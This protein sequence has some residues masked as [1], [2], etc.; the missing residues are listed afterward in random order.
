MRCRKVINVW[1]L[2]RS[3]FKNVDKN[4]RHFKNMLL[5][6]PTTTFTVNYVLNVI[7]AYY[8]NCKFF[9]ISI[10][11]LC[12]QHQTGQTFE[13]PISGILPGKFH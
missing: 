2:I 11:R 8:N 5:V 10:D 12:K 9:V 4:S 1:L 6:H 7:L 13:C 3:R